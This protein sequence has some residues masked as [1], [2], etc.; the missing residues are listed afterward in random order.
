VP[1]GLYTDKHPEGNVVV[2]ATHT[3]SFQSHKLSFLLKESQPFIG[4]L[5]ILD[6]GLDPQFLSQTESVYHLVDHPLVNSIL[7]HRQRFSHKGDYGTGALI[8]GSTG[9]MGAAALCARAFMRS[10][11]GK[12][13]C[14]VPK[15]GY[16]IMQVGVPE[17][18]VMIEGEDYVEKIG[19]LEKYDAVG[20]GPGLGKHDG[21]EKLF[22]DILRRYRQP[23]VIDADGLNILARHPKLL[24]QLPPFSVLTP[25]VGEFERLFGSFKTDFERIESALVKARELDVLIVLKGP[26]TFIATPGG[27][28][29][30]N[31]TGNPGMATG[32]SGDV[33]TG[34]IT[35]LICQGYPSEHAAIAG[36]YL[37]GLA[38]DLAAAA[39]SQ[40]SLI[41]TDL[42]NYFGQAF[43][44]FE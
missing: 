24:K 29:Y 17:A 20:I 33:L 31:S 34:F 30:F 40:A 38:G 8:A 44:S 22:S 13:I 11:A 4:E 32:G 15:S 25:H 37:H 21:Q 10:G 23:L 28:G 12:L 14:H 36:V 1:T 3:L 2:R 35:G 43:K 9:M 39:N 42:V 16:A 41:A 19:S 5:H 7:R 6:I 26:Y 18:M 27:K